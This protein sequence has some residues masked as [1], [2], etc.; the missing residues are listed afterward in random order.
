[1]R[2][3]VAFTVLSCSAT[4]GSSRF[5]MPWMCLEDCGQNATNIA[6]QL[7][8]FKDW[9]VFTDVS[10]EDW[11]LGPNMTLIKG[12]RTRVSPELAAMG[13]G[14]QA[15]VV[16]VNLSDMRAVFE[17]PGAFIDAVT[18]L[19]VS[20]ENLTAINLDWEPGQ[21]TGPN[22]TPADGAAYAAFLNVFADAM[23]H[24]GMKVSVDIATWTPFWN[25]ALLGATRVDQLCDMETY[26]ANFTFFEQQV[27][28]AQTHISPEQ[29]VVGLMTTHD[30][31]PKQGLPFSTAEL[32]ERFEFLANRS[33]H[34]IAMWDSPLQD[35]WL[36]FLRA[37]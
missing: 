33:V 18:T 14:R 22:P 19:V 12:K 6:A 34:Q 26:N 31:G 5:V 9:G 15:M 24:I 21:G 1:M 20:E 4:L 7:Q 27:A 11:T 23:H 16:G 10:F 28:F 8:Q 2:P 35:N 29:L 17:A 13:L 36:Q 3:L 30:S 32:A 25:Y 37:F